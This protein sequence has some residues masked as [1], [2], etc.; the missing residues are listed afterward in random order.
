MLAEARLDAPCTLAHNREGSTLQGMLR[1]R[2]P[3]GAL[4]LPLQITPGRRIELPVEED[5][6][7]YRALEMV[8]AFEAARTASCRSRPGDLS[9]ELTAVFIGL[10][11]PDLQAHA[12]RAAQHCSY[13]NLSLESPFCDWEV[14]R[15]AW[16]L[17]PAT[18]EGSLPQ[19][20]HGLVQS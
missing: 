12:L 15:M 1:L 7:L 10:Y 11:L 14:V 20:W 9:P 3:H 8:S 13:A 4:L 17:A 2:E 19:T 6:T 18:S 5:P 16:K